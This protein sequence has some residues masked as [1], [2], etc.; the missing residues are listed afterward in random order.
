MEP[1]DFFDQPAALAVAMK[2]LGTDRKA[3]GADDRVIDPA[4]TPRVEARRSEGPVED[5]GFEPLTS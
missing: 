2:V 3:K 5:R 1:A 4:V